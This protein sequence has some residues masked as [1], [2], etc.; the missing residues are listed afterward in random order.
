MS[1]RRDIEI[2]VREVALSELSSEDQELVAKAKEIVSVAYAPYSH[3]HVAAA[4]RLESGRVVL[5]T[6]QENASY[7]LGL[8]AE[9]T[10]LF[11]SGALYPDDPVVSL[12]IVGAREDGMIIKTCAP[13]GGCRQV[14]LEMADRHHHPFPVILAG[15]ESA[16]VVEDCRDLLPINFDA[17]SL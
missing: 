5:G 1:E 15:P 9:R 16:L 13:C 6:N 8:C 4:L 7:P 14:M 12:V 3:F 11:Q 2:A 17:S 10:A